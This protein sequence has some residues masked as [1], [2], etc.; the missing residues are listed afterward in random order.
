[1]SFDF[2]LD[3][4]D[5]GVAPTTVV[6]ETKAAVPF[7]DVPVASNTKPE[8]TT[9]PV[10]RVK[11]KRASRDGILY[12]DLET[13]PDYERMES[14]GLEPIRPRG[15][16]ISGSEVASQL[17]GTVKEIEE[18]LARWNPCDEGIQQV[19]NC[20]SVQA[21]P[22]KGVLDLL[23]KIKS[24]DDDRRKTMSLSPEMC[25]IVAFGWALGDGITNAMVVGVMNRTEEDLVRQF[26]TLA[27]SAKQLCGFNVL[28]F[29]LPVIFTRSILLDVAP[30]NKPI[31]M[32]PWGND[33]VDLMA[34]RWTKGPATGIKKLAA[35][36]GIPVPAGDVD[37]SQVE[38]L[39][40][41]DPLKLGEYV[42][43]DVH[44]NQEVHRRYQGFFC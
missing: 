24:Q 23:A 27:Q 25:R 18:W 6:A 15:A 9:V 2:N 34:K 29:D 43:S 30:P 26:W 12:F 33:V 41:S 39:H 37:G 1:M 14:F 11:R 19:V 8:I 38:A 17:K 28:N 7:P 22:R 40:K 20:E 10:E 16:A 35:M 32:K 13:V 36:L 42:R 5:L 21:K 4:L 31:D 3:D 44:L